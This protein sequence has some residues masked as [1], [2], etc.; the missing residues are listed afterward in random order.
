MDEIKDR[1]RETCN[2]IDGWDKRRMRW[3][4]ICTLRLRQMGKEPPCD[5]CGAKET[6]HCCG[7]G[8]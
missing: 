4:D 3:R 8:D 1:I 6:N 7:K 2:A 5:D